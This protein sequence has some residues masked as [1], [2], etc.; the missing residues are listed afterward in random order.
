MNTNAESRYM[1]EFF[2]PDEFTTKM[3]QTIPSQRRMVNNLFTE[4]KLISYTLAADRSMLWAVF[5]CDSESKLIS[6]VESLPM[7]RYFTYRYHEIMFHEMVSLFPAVS[8]N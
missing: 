6:L 8:L 1:V 4:G 3:M 2:L 5:N 7:T